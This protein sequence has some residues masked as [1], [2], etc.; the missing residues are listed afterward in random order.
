M[1]TTSAGIHDP[2]A[3]E[4]KCEQAPEET[5]DK[6]EHHIHEGISC[7]NPLPRNIPRIFACTS[8][9]LMSPRGFD[10]NLGGSRA[11]APIRT[12]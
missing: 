10:G 12:I 11:V 9:P 2:D 6:R 3:L 4:A 5:G 7:R 1:S 8:T